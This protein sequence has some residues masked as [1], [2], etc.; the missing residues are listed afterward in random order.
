MGI[1]YLSLYLHSANT[2]VCIVLD[3]R[4]TVAGLRNDA[5][6]D[7]DATVHIDTALDASVNITTITMSDN[8]DEL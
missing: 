6:G 7:V 3:P 1:E 4:I 2:D 5:V 8:R